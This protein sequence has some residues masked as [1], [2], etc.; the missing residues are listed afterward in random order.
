MRTR[1]TVCQTPARQLAPS[2]GKELGGGLKKRKEKSPTD[3][4]I[5][6]FTLKPSPSK[7]AHESG[8][9]YG[10]VVW[11]LMS[12]MPSKQTNNILN[13]IMLAQGQAGIGAV[14]THL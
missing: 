13:A 12:Q 14:C 4:V 1:R 10:I 5:I 3:F 11:R 2:Q 9:P 7:K 8:Q 6:H